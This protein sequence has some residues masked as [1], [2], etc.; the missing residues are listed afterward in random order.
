MCHNMLIL[1]NKGIKKSSKEWEDESI[2]QGSIK[3][4]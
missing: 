1:L 2:K 4:G 3:I